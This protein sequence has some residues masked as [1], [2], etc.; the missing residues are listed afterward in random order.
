MEC[1][2]GLNYII[3]NL[4]GKPFPSLPRLHRH[5]REKH[6]T[7]SFKSMAPNGRSRYGRI[8]VKV[9]DT[10]GELGYGRQLQEH[11]PQWKEQVL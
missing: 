5:I 2:R 6:V 8:R 1:G 7:N 3:N 10:L 9:G 4:Q 11:G